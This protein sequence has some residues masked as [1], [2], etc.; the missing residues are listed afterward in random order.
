MPPDL[1]PAVFLDRDGVIV[2]NRVGYVRSVAEVRFIPGALEAL[3][4]L[5]QS[6]RLIV[7][8]TNQSAI[9]R[10]L[11]TR[12]TADA[13]NACVVAAIESAGGRV[14]GLYLCPHRPDENCRCRKP[15]PG[16]LLD[17]ARDLSIDL[18]ASVLIGDA[19]SDVQAAQA[20][21]AQSILVLSGR[22]SAEELNGAGLNHIR[23]APDLAAAVERLARPTK[24]P[25][26]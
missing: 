1:K 25:P 23:T 9:G 20:A 16:L 6:G 26:T 14:D 7:I 5:A 15:A 4:R 10:G 19:L 8:V 17:A 2:E 24:T 12:E 18:A 11:L 3:A 22:G 21:G 13:I